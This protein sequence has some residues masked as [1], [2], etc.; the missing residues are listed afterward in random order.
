MREPV[1]VT[2]PAH[3]TVDDD[4]TSIAGS[5]VGSMRDMWQRKDAD[6]SKK[7]S[8]LDFFRNRNMLANV[9]QNFFSQP[10]GGVSFLSVNGQA[11]N[12]TNLN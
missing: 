9:L 5:D 1:V 12:L 4:V 8:E 11:P 6:I 10:Y 7:K 2:R 3:F